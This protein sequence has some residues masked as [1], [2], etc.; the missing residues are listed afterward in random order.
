[1]PA[2]SGAITNRALLLLLFLLLPGFFELLTQLEV[3]LGE[4]CLA[5]CLAEVVPTAVEFRWRPSSDQAASSS[6]GG[7]SVAI[8]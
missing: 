6:V 8:V 7:T 2:S 1:M 5:G 4:E 3:L